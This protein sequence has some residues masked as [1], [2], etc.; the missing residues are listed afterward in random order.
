MK[1]LLLLPGYLEDST[2]FDTLRSF[3]PAAAEVRA[4]ELEQEFARWQPAGPASAVTLA[5]YLASRYAI[6]PADV[7]IGH[8]MGRLGGRP[9]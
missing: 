5:R 1:R 8:S 7:L 9:P 4:I 6:G 3:L 2:I